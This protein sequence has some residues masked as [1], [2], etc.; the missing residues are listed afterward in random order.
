M[1]EW[2]IPTHSRCISQLVVLSSS[3]GMLKVGVFDAV[4]PRCYFLPSIILQSEPGTK[5]CS[6]IAP[7]EREC[8]M[9]PKTAFGDHAKWR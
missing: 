9:E 2:A 4:M 6:P 5:L 3:P 1:P 8:Q 7:R